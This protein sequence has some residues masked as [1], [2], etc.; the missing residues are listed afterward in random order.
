MLKNPLAYGC[1]YLEKERDSLLVNK[2]N[3]LIVAAATRLDKCKMIRFEERTGIFYVTE[4][5]M[6]L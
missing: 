6:K 5:G 1:T 2:R 3:E 4:L